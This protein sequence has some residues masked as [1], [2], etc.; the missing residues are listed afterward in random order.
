M[1][2]GT[3]ESIRRSRWILAVI[4]LAGF[5]LRLHVATGS[6]YHWDEEREWIPFA[7]SISVE[8]GHVHLPI[9]AISHPIMPAYIIKA[10]SVV[11]GENE[12]GFR[13]MSILAGTL[14][15]LVVAWIAWRWRGMT[16]AIIA[17]ALL[18]FNEYH[19]FVSTIAIDKPFQLLFVALAI[20]GF[21]HFLLE[22]KSRGLYFAGAM[23]GLAFLCKETSGLLLPGFLISLLVSARYRRWLARPAPYLAVLAF[24]AVISP[25]LYVNYFMSS[26]LEYTYA[27]HLHRAAGIGF[28]RQHLLFFFRDSIRYVYNLR[29]EHLTDLA[30]EYASMNSV[31]GLVFLG[32]ATWTLGRAVV[33]RTARADDVPT[34]LA[35]AFWMVFGFFLFISVSHTG[36]IE[37]LTYT[38]WFWS[39]LTLIPGAA[40]AGAFF[41]GLVGRWRNAALAVPALGALIAVYA[42]A[43]HRVNTPHGPVVG[44]AP[45]YLMPPDGHVADVHASFN[46]CEICDSDVK[47][48]LVDVKLHEPDGTT[49]SVLGTPLATVGPE[50]DGTH[51]KL[52]AR[53]VSPDM[54]GIKEPWQEVYWYE[55]SYALT[56][57]SGHREV[58]Q[59]RVFSQLR[60]T[61]YQ[62]RFWTLD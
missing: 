56:D 23:T 61:E 1:N 62:P 45:E 21:V 42:A 34:Y 29:G 43:V 26:D 24:V 20:A 2:P 60:P 10:G 8:P 9:R 52:K 51:L 28:T 36:A 22:E 49:T 53:D 12:L 38:A 13:I 47:V 57:S 35:I 18:A 55:V 39:D 19:I 50:P 30:P 17:A 27:D 41:A 14:T 15:I 59:D 48:E 4:V 46:F 25:D 3:F 37:H 32:V 7:K 16:A 31:L 58:I 40:L 6:V 11:L 33:S 54:I 5:L 44:F